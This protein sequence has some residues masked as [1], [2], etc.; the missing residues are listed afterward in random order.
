MPDIL[1]PP[2]VSTAIIQPRQLNR[3]LDINPQGGPLGRTQ[4][5]ITLPSFNVAYTWKG[6][7]EIVA[8]FNFEG[9][10]NFS[11]TSLKTELPIS[12][13]YFLCIMWSD[14]NLSVYRYSLW[15]GVGEVIY[16]NIPVY[17][18]QKIGKNFRFE[19]WST[20]TGNPAINGASINFYTSVLGI[21]DYRFGVDSALVSSDPIVT[22]FYD[23]IKTAAIPN[24]S[25]NTLTQHFVS[26]NGFAS[27]NWNSL[28]DITTI[29]SGTAVLS[30]INQG[31][32]IFKAVTTGGTAL[33]CSSFGGGATPIIRYIGLLVYVTLGSIGDLVQYNN[34]PPIAINGINLLFGSNMLT[35]PASNTLYFV[36]ADYVNNIGY[37]YNV[38]TQQ[39][40]LVLLTPASITASTTLAVNASQTCGV[41][42]MFSYFNNNSLQNILNYI[43]ATYGGFSLPLTFPTGSVPQ[44]N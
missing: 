16:F 31:P 11:L 27:P 43:F 41:L 26:T 9:P 39:E 36:W 42:E 21:Y 7:S 10:N 32:N 37:V 23:N 19:V 20:A 4:T 25:Q 18:G 24:N 33:T 22:N 3:W 2:F 13:N 1:S 15:S 35:L 29:S 28:S 8:A 38:Y 17:T 6:Y 5:F 34:S 12:P 44:H 40:Y 30:S 14:S